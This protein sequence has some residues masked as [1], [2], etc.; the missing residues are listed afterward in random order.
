MS[1]AP[2]DPRHREAGFTLIELIVCLTIL[3]AI[4]ALLA[5]GLRSLS[6]GA[7]RN[8]ERIQML[9]MISRAFDILKRDV[10]GL[11][12]IAINDGS[13]RYLFSGTPEHLRFVTIEPPYPAAEGPY[14]VDYS[15]SGKQPSLLIRARSPLQPGQLSYSGATPANRVNLMEGRVSYRFRYGARSEKGLTWHDAWPYANR[16]PHVIRLDII[17]MR[18]NLPASPAFVAELR[19]NAEIGCLDETPAMCSANPQG[20]LQATVDDDGSQL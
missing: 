7:D 17:D 9:D 3:A 14:F 16:L 5:G 4:L 13:A 19:A 15:V 20:E 12:R 2:T 6:Q 10:N 1:S 8:S 11:Q 18:T